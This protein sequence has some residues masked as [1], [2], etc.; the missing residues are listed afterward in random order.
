MREIVN[1]VKGIIAIEMLTAYRGM[2]KYGVS[3]K[4]LNTAFSIM[5]DTIGEFKGDMETT[6]LIEKITTMMNSNKMLEEIPIKL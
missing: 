5:N 3:G 6:T 4:N 2:E 1:N